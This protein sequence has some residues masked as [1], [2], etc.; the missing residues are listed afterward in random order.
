MNTR[1]MKYHEKEQTSDIPDTFYVVVE[2]PA[3]SRNKYEIH[4]G[5]LMLDRVLHSSLIYPLNYGF[6]P[7]TLAKDGDALDALI[8][9]RFPLNSQAIVHV[10][11]IAIL[12]MVD[13]AGEDN[14]ILTVP[15][16]DSFFKETE[17]Y[18]DVQKGLLRE[19]EQ[20]FRRYKELEEGKESKVQG[21]F[22]KKEAKS[23]IRDALKRY[24]KSKTTP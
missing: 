17:G 9:T 12:K 1:K 5:F 23:C 21:W 16:N 2:I 20:F 22:N 15:I 14:K 13:E 24:N 7:R 11:P 18:E 4:E 19:I 6:L 10:R 3:Q 8:W